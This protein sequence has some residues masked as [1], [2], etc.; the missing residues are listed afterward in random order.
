MWIFLVAWCNDLPGVDFAGSGLSARSGVGRGAT[1]LDEPSAFAV[2]APFYEQ[3]CW[4]ARAPA[5]ACE[6]I[7]MPCLSLCLQFELNG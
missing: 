5:A 6:F 1:L 3:L 4:A 2:W 7:F